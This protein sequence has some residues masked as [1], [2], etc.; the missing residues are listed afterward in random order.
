MSRK[1]ERR[2]KAILEQL[3]ITPTMRVGRLAETLEVTTETIRRD[4]EELA[5]QG[6]IARTY[7]GAMLRQP[8]EPALSERH[9][10]LVEERAAIG[11][12]AA[13]LLAGARV[14]MMG[15]GA[16][17]TQ[18][19]RRIA[20][21]MSEV[22]VI[23]HSVSVAAALAVNPS[24]QVVVAPGV[25]HAGEGALHGAQTVRFLSDYSADWSVTGASAMSPL[26]PSDAL[27]EAGDVYA[28][29]LRQSAR[30]MVVA[31]HSK[32]DRMATARYSDWGEIDV[33]VSDAR[34]QGPLGRALQLAG[35]GV[36]LAVL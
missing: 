2:Q 14:I 5:A 34:P 31:D 27:I 20:L 16:T 11:R 28:T 29:M 10:E 19:A 32:F 8:M 21:E 33:L 22:T 35:V 17:T 12:A 13:P 18:I 9:K 26:G 23:A 30:H 1:K 24:I 7:G 6:L 4:L 15:S 36:R 25:Y 3:S